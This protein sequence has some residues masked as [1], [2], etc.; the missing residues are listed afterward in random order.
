MSIN[1]ISSDSNAINIA[2][3]GLN[4]VQKQ[5]SAI[6]ESIASG[7][8]ANIEA[9]NMSISEQLN[10]QSRASAVATQNA[11]MGLSLTDTASSALSDIN[12]SLERINELAM[13]S[14]NGTYSDTQR[15]MMQEEVNQHVEQIN[16]T[17]QNS[18]FNDIKTLNLV[19]TS[20]PTPIDDVQFQVGTDSSSSST[21]S[22]DPNMEMEP[23]SIDVS[24]QASASAN[25]NNISNMMNTVGAKQAE[26]G[27]V[28]SRLENSI[29]ANTTNYINQQSA[30][31]NIADTDYASAMVDLVNTNITSQALLQVIKVD[32]QSKG[33]L[34]DLIAGASNS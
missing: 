32:S 15:Q 28:Q 7:V 34:L 6:A 21:V 5:Q 22:Y 3:A 18:S 31:S 16:Q 11:Q 27:A 8:N 30:Y 26:I 12:S 19:N 25:L 17:I 1:S 13:Q 20:S 29:D 33:F 2:L 9:A 23:I 24:T 4:K 10:A 14:A